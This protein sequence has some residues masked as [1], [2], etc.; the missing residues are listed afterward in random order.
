[1][2]VFHQFIWTILELSKY[3]IP[4]KDDF[5]E[6]VGCAGWGLWS[7]IM[8]GLGLIPKDVAKSSLEQTR[9]DDES[10]LK[11]HTEKLLHIFTS[12]IDAKYRTCLDLKKFYAYIKK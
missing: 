4:N 6:T 8:A 2:V 1:M 9:F 11:I 12:D 3:K 7:Y 5:P 10:N